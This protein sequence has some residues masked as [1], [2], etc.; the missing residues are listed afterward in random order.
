M[1]GRFLETRKGPAGD[2]LVGQGPIYDHVLCGG[3]ERGGA[4]W[5]VMEGFFFFFSSVVLRAMSCHGPLA[6]SLHP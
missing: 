1:D 6:L 5:L 4:V 2:F 3:G